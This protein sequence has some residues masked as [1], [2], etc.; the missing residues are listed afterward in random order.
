MSEP[1]AAVPEPTEIASRYIVERKLGAGA[2]G[3]VY[4][5]KDKILGRMIAIKTIRLEGLAASAASLDELLKRFLREAQVSAQLKHPNI[6]TIY[7]IGEVAGMSY[8]AMEFI[9]G[10]GLEKVIRDAG[11]L[12]IERAA[13]IAAQVADALD[14][15]HRHNVVHRDI[16]PANIM[17]EAGDRVKV[18][19]FGIARVTNSADQ[20]TATGGLLGTPSYMSPEQAKG[21]ELDGRSDLFSVGCVLYEML[22]GKRSF[23]GDSITGLI[24]K[25]ITEDPQPMKELRS[26]VPDEM[27]KVVAKAM[28]KAQNARY[29]S[30]RELKDA[31]QAFVGAGAVP[32][33]RQ[34]ET[35]TESLP[36]LG[37]D[38]VPTAQLQATIASAATTAAAAGPGAV[39]A[40]VSPPPLPLPKAQSATRGAA[41]ARQP[42]RG[43]PGS[44][45]LFLGLAALGTILIG[46][47]LAGGWLLFRPKEGPP[48]AS[49]APPATAPP[50]TAAPA[51]LTSSTTPAAAAPAEAPANPVTLPPS[52]AGRS[53][54]ATLPT[55]RANAGAASADQPTLT[56][57]ST[58]PAAPSQRAAARRLAP[59]E[60][61]AAGEF[62]H[63][64]DEQAVDGSEAGRRVADKF[65][66]G[67]SSSSFGASG[68]RL[69]A[70]SR[71]PP[72][73]APAERPAVATV[74]HLI[75]AEEAYNRKHGRYAPLSD[76]VQ[77]RLAMLDVQVSGNGFQRRNYRFQLV[78]ED[79]GFRV[80]AQP[81]GPA[82][83]SFVGDDTGVV[84]V[85]LQ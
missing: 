5:A 58:S 53:A 30:G 79:D 56:P 73:V 13:A 62:S 46:G 2:F 70:R 65:R 39:V 10:V 74:L 63:L 82:G 59:P 6:V 33:I 32:T 16:K 1:K 43:R 61:P 44:T 19:D 22:T 76:L 34:S 28:A 31:L 66:S 52:T 24:F 37:E 17:L 11:P 18:A 40:P 14:Y 23:R 42:S 81:I 51:S 75:A 49:N 35:P 12:P 71:I 41:E 77:S 60:P 29:Q 85:G 21:N 78:V 8:L 84:R 20:L 83:R 57:D 67:S 25:V 15:A 27:V 38:S 4:K 36:E 50:T 47:L 69:R 80:V 72:A 55:G 3:T 48:I 9:D 68:S 26:D 54:A 45:G 7:D 64:D